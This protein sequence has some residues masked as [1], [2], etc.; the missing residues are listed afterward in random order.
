MGKRRADIFRIFFDHFRLPYEIVVHIDSYRKSNERSESQT[1][2]SQLHSYY[3]GGHVPI[4][5]SDIWEIKSGGYRSHFYY[6]EE[7]AKKIRSQQ[8]YQEREK[9]RYELK[10]VE[11][12]LKTPKPKNTG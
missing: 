7:Q 5:E 8:K 12:R 2:L 4:P 9:I 1:F 10:L 11:R 6:L 3:I